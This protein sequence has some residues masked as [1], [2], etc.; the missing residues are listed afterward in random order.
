MIRIERLTALIWKEWLQVFR[1]PSALMIAFLLPLIMIFLFGYGLS[2]DATS[3]KLGVALEDS[4][5]TARSFFNALDASRYFSARYY[6]N[7]ADAEAGLCD[8]DVRAVLVIPNDFSKRVEEGTL[9]PAQLLVDGADANTA[10][11]VENYATAAYAQWSATRLR[12]L[13]GLDGFS[14]INLE[15]RTIYNP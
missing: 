8:G 11:I 14:K 7:R 9:G 15:T 6:T 13:R 3:V 10:L 12:E 1:D 4:S 2:L 5:P